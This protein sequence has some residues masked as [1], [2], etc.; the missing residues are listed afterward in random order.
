M[1]ITIRRTD[2]AVITTGAAR[3]L[4]AGITRLYNNALGYIPRRN[5]GRLERQPGGDT[6]H[7]QMGFSAGY[8]SVSLDPLVVVQVDD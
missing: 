6:Y 1:Q 5:I 4:D 2:G 7:V 3:Q 8:G